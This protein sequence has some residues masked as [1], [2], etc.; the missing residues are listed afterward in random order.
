MFEDIPVSTVA[1]PFGAGPGFAAD[2]TV[3][4]RDVVYI[5]DDNLLLTCAGPERLVEAVGVAVLACRRRFAE[6]GLELNFKP[7]KSELLID[8][9]GRGSREVRTSLFNDRRGVFEV[10]LGGRQVFVWDGVAVQGG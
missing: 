2:A 9:R 8:P 3:Q 10:E 7:G 4:A 5:D 1:S 6:H